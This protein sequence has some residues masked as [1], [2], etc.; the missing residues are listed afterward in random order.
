MVRLPT[1]FAKKGTNQIDMSRCHRISGSPV[2]KF[3]AGLMQGAKLS[4]N[5]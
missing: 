5:L 4:L 3:I 2:E 1:V